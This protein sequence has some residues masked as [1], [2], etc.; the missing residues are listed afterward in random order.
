MRK[1]AIVDE[2]SL[3]P[4]AQLLKMSINELCQYCW[5]RTHLAPQTGDV[6][7]AG[8]STLIKVV[9]GVIPLD[10]ETRNQLGGNNAKCPTRRIYRANPEG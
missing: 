5:W 7:G 2:G 9:V 6:D 1:P 4:L 10:K 8:K 3:T